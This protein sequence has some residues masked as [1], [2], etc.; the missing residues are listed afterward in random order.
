L[1]QALIVIAA[2]LVFWLV[3]GLTVTSWYD[4]RGLYRVAP[5]LLAYIEEAADRRP[6]P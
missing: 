4:R 6:R 2:E 5:D 1:T 3:V